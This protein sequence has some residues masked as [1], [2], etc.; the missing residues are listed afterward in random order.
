[1]M[2]SLQGTGEYDNLS[3]LQD[4]LAEQ[5]IIFNLFST[6]AKLSSKKV[7]GID[8][9]GRVISRVNNLQDKKALPQVR[10]YIL[11]DHKD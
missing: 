2:L 10:R 3:T 5:N 11:S 4:T 1:M 8:W 7:I 6:Y 9:E